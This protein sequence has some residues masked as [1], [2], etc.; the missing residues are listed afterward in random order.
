MTFAFGLFVFAT[1]TAS[2]GVWILVML[3][4]PGLDNTMHRLTITLTILAFVF[5]DGAV[6][7]IMVGLP[8]VVMRLLFGMG[9]GVQLVG[10]L[11]AYLFLRDLR[12]V[13]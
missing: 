3:R 10:A 5:I 11:S 1:A 6:L 4:L 8:E 9:M 13:P 7:S 12:R 2:A